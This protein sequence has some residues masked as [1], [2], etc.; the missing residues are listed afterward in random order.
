MGAWAW[1]EPCRG[2]ERHPLFE[3]KKTEKY[4]LPARFGTTSPEVIGKQ[5]SVWNS[6]E[7]LSKTSDELRT[8]I[9]VNG[10]GEY[11]ACQSF[12]MRL[13]SVSNQIQPNEVLYA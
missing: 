8:A 11:F 7:A 12:S 9:E 13:P 4:T 2:G 1:R 6:G 3:L 10:S 5:W